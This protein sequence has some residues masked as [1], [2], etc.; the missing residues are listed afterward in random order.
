[1]TKRI[2][3]LP[4][5]TLAQRVASMSLAELLTAA[6]GLAPKTDAASEE[7]CQAVLEQLEKRTRNSSDFQA[8][9]AEIYS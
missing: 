2:G 6:R 7:A 5:A 1:M 3:T 9:V 8:F 4:E